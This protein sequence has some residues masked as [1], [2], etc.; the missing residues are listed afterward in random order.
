MIKN[1]LEKNLKKLKPWATRHQIEA[2]R[3]YD[4]DIPEFPFIIDV[5]KDYF[6]VHDKSDSFLDKEKNHLPLVL[7]A[8]KDIFACA[9][10]KI[11]LKK[12]ERQEGLKQYEKL[13]QKSDTFI[14]RESQAVFKVNMYDYLDTGLFLD[15]RPMRQKVFKTASGKKFLNLFCYTGSVSVFAALGGARTTSVDMSQ[16]YLSWAQDNFALNQIDLGAHSFVN[17]NVLEWLKDERYKN[18]FD[19]IFLDPPTFSNSKKMEDSFEVE[20]DQDFLVD[21]C[22]MMLNPGGVLYFSN[23]KRKFKLS[24]SLQEKYSVVDK[25]EE[26]I[27]QDFHD[28]KIHNCFEIR[29]K[30]S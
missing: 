12:R 1:R 7:T 18:K 3:L 21:S 6:L 15:H 8:I 10:D 16:T 19:I 25:T 24:A 13:D 5:Y 23:N 20:R 27:P 4:R 14:V 26:S 30:M 2:Y 11:I 28:K 29:A 22:M 17:A 9:D